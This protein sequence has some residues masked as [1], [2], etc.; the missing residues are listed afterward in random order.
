MKSTTASPLDDAFAMLQPLESEETN[1]EVETRQHALNL[2]QEKSQHADSLVRTAISL[3][4]GGGESKSSK[5]I[6]VYMEAADLYFG[7]IHISDQ[8]VGGNQEMV[9]SGLKRKHDRVLEHVKQLKAGNTDEKGS[10]A[11]LLCGACMR[12]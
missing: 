3:E 1:D 5:I 2:I 7:A 4:E 10:I 11:F 8:L 12:Y 6:D 9:A